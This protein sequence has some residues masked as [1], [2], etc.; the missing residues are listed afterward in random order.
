M[1]H[2]GFYLQ[3]EHVALAQKALKDDYAENHFTVTRGV[4]LPLPHHR[5]SRY[6][7]TILSTW[8]ITQSEALIEYSTR[9]SLGTQ[10]SGPRLYE[11]HGNTQLLQFSQMLQRISTRFVYLFNTNP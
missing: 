1:I 7:V 2:V 4:A 8:T 9:P 6:C 10:K 11:T 3:D 5:A